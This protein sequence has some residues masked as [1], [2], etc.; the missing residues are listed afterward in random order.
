MDTPAMSGEKVRGGRAKVHTMLLKLFVKLQELLSR[1]E[2][3]DLVEYALIVALLT[4]GVAAATKFLAAGLASTF[5][6]ISSS[7]GS[8]VT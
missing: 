7:V 1:E 5:G 4:F 8:Y 6:N 2:G 3:Q